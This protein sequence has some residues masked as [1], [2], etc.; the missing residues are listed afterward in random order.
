MNVDMKI[1][2]LERKIKLLLKES[3]DLDA[4]KKGNKETIDISCIKTYKSQLPFSFYAQKKGNT[5]IVEDSHTSSFAKII[6]IKHH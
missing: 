4:I 6:K 5:S 1:K 3:N 2:V